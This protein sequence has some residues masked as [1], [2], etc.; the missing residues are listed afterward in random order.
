MSAAVVQLERCL[1]EVSHWMSANR[2]KLN[3]DK[4]ELLWAVS[5]YS[6]SSLGSRGLSLQV[7]QTLS[8][9]RTMFACS[10]SPSR[11]TSALTTCFQRLCS[12]FLL[13]SP[14]S[15]SSTVT[16]RRVCE[17]T[18]PRLCHSPGAWTTATWFSLVHQGLLLTN[19]SGY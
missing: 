16:G 19:C 8:R 12:M 11:P 7:D 2:L 15:T 6:Q 17:D 3:P 4:T 5:N 14:T 10:A 18:C 1:A 9:R 13:A